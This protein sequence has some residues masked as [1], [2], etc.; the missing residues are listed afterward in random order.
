MALLLAKTKYGLVEGLPSDN[1]SISVFKG[2]PFA[3]PPIGNLRWQAPK[4]PEPWNNILKAYNYQP[5]PYQ[6]RQK[7]GTT[8]QLEFY[9]CEW[10]RSE[11]CLYLNIWTPAE[12]AGETLPVALWIF[13]GGFHRGYSNKQETDGD[14]F[15]R[16][17]CIYVSFNYRLSVFGFL[18]HPELTKEAPYGSS[19]NYGLLDQIAALK[20]VYENISAFGGDPERITIFGQS[21]GAKSVQNLTVSPL[22]SSYVSGTIIQSG[23]GLHPLSSMLVQNTREHECLGEAFF[24][25][26]GV[27]SLAQARK[28]DEATIYE[29]HMDFLRDRPGMHFVPHVDGYALPQSPGNMLRFGKH[30]DIPCIIGYNKDESSLMPTPVNEALL[31]EK[32]FNTYILQR[33]GKHGPEMLE[34]LNARTYEDR[35]VYLSRGNLLDMMVPGSNA[36]AQ[37]Y[38]EKQK[39]PVYLYVFAHTPP[40][41]P[42]VGVYHSAEKMYIH[43]TINRNW[44][45]MKVEDYKLS[46]E[47]ADYWANFVKTH[48]PN[49]DGL[50]K[51]MP[52]TTNDPSYMEMKPNC[53]M[54]QLE[55]TPYMKCYRKI[56][57]AEDFGK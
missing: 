23:G 37:M 32:A 31:E 46:L 9:P 19:G 33:F 8:T 40:G 45:P 54:R 13:G 51:W 55:E 3:K 44:R 42:N 34:A 6:Y 28:I 14:G 47:M 52:F 56:L 49:G 11:D 16:R 18:A 50:A 26:L 57:S 4:E 17:G 30:P 1:Q 24:K 25:Y 12:S 38:A 27:S 20:W 35:K 15:A 48:N 2:I 41:E 36:Y 39:N 10:P 29:K 53:E 5:V 7:K 21:A 43:E 22:S